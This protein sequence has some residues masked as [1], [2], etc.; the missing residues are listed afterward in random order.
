[1]RPPLP[2]ASIASGPEGLPRDPKAEV[3]TRWEALRAK[4]FPAD[5]APGGHMK[6]QEAGLRDHRDRRESGGREAGGVA[7]SRLPKLRPQGNQ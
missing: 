1:M 2:L 7:S 4:T 6:G 3:A 5:N